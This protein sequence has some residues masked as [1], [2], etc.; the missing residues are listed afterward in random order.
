[1]AMFSWSSLHQENPPAVAKFREILAIIPFRRIWPNYIVA[2]NDEL[3]FCGI[4]PKF[5][6]Y[7]SAVRG[8]N[9]RVLQNATV[10]RLASCGEGDGEEI[11]DDEER[12]RDNVGGA[13]RRRELRSRVKVGGGGGGDGDGS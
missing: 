10:P 12:D 7:G 9:R 3:G 13:R 1:M 6:V 2:G 4:W 8:K 11:E 5:A